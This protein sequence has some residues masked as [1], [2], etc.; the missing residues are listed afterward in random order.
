MLLTPSPDAIE[1]PASEP[2]SPSASPS[3]ELGEPNPLETSSSSPF[4]SPSPTRDDVLL[5]VNVAMPATSDVTAST[6]SVTPPRSRLPLRKG[7]YGLKV[8]TLQ[9]RL[10]WLGY[11]VPT[12]VR[13]AFGVTTRAAV[14]SF[15]AKNW[16]PVTGKVNKR[17]WRTLK[18]IAG[19]VDA[20]PPECTDVK[21]SLC[22]DKTARVL[23]L[24]RKGEVTLTTDARFGQRGMETDEGV[25][26]VKEKSYNH[27]SSKYGSWMPR[28]MFFNGDEAVHYSPD[29][30]S[31]G[32]LRGSHGCVGLRDMDI[33]TRLFDKVPVG[34]RV[35]VYWS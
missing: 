22:I 4:A 9:D 29:F 7:H 14:K 24:V 19:P 8:A 18:R 17:T 13:G 20:L 34:T 25:F 10:A 26:A 16:L 31:V 28:A 3:F 12:S 21:M 11:P 5:S 33:A 15:Q 6:A 32:Y 27:T 30:A 2:A 23:R 1:P 35:V